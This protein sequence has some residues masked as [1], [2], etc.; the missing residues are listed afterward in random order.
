MKPRFRVAWVLAMLAALT[1]TDARVCH[2]R[3]R[4]ATFAGEISGPSASA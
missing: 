1:A 3:D 2:S 4:A